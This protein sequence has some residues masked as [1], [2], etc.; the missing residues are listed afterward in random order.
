VLHT[1]A[2]TISEQGNEPP[3]LDTANDMVL[4]TKAKLGELHPTPQAHR[5]APFHVYTAIWP[6]Q[7]VKAAYKLLR[8]W[9]TLTIMLEPLLGIGI[10]R[11][12]VYHLGHRTQPFTMCRI[13]IQKRCA[14]SPSGVSHRDG[15]RNLLQDV[16][17]LGLAAPVAKHLEPVHRL[18][19]LHSAGDHQDGGGG[20]D[21]D[22]DDDD[23]D[24]EAR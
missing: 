8:S 4:H 3:L 24:V 19:H 23:D 7:S 9:Q 17:D 13:Q 10:H 11:A 2:T 14:P 21:D 20:D 1:K 12:C 18:V 5:E 22:D 15:G 6:N 16:L